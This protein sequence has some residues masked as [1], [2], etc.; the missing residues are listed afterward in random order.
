[1]VFFI[2]FNYS[3]TDVGI[4]CHVEDMCMSIYSVAPFYIIIV[5]LILFELL[6]LKLEIQ[7]A[8]SFRHFEK[9]SRV[10]VICF[11]RA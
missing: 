6:R 9:W 1:M 5:T 2:F 10:I 3:N 7:P 8:F 11:F 4:W